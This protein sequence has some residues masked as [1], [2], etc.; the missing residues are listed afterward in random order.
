MAA[1]V[2]GIQI[3]CFAIQVLGVG[4]RQ[5]QRRAA[6]A[7]PEQLGVRH[8]LPLHGLAQQLL[9]GGLVGDVVKKHVGFISQNRLKES[10]FAQSSQ[11]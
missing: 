1:T 9:D 8:V 5:R 4:Q 2:F 3:A 10:Y 11:S 7:A 6:L